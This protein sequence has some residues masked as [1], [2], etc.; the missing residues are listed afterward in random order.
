MM[1]LSSSDDFVHVGY[2]V[3]ISLGVA[4]AWQECCAS[5]KPQEIPLAL[6]QSLL[7]GDNHL[8]IGVEK[9]FLQRVQSSQ[10]NFIKF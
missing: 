6:S 1:H 3:Y 8:S 4:S 2:A 10:E 9:A 7:Y 5:T